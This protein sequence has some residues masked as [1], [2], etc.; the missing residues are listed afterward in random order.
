MG[1]GIGRG[2][3]YLGGHAMI[4]AF[5]P[6]TAPLAISARVGHVRGTMARTRAFDE[7]EVL[8][9]AMALFWRQ[10]F[11]A[12]SIGD[13]VNVCGINR[14]SMYGAF[15]DKRRLF[16]AVL[17][18]YSA[19]VNAERL[20]IL[21]RDGS[22][23][24]AIGGFFDAIVRAATGPERHLGRLITN[25]L[26]EIAPTDP[27]IAARLQT[28]LQRIETAFTKAIRRGQD[29]G[30]I[31]PGKNARAHARFMVGVAQ[32]LRVL[33]RNGTAEATLRDI[34]STALT[35]LR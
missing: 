23:I 30:E 32:G 1:F 5:G 15:G 20:A 28:N 18:H 31:A 13:L 2:F 4:P 7:E 26:T 34:V 12:T 19:R 33:A 24:A 22:A 25:T 35:T 6:A 27:G 11:E 9:R 3:D 16:I 21:S 10:G 29:N 14:A 17:D 8:D